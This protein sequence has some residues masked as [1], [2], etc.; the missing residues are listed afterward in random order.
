MGIAATAPLRYPAGQRRAGGGEKF[1]LGR[2][3]SSY[4]S[5]REGRSPGEFILATGTLA[6]Q[7]LLSWR[8]RGMLGTSERPAADLQCGEKRASGEREEVEASCRELLT[9]S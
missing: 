9:R 5:N 3:L 1:E 7:G 6:S 2:R 8:K 4:Q